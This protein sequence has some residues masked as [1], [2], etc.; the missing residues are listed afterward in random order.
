MANGDG[1]FN[2]TTLWIVGAVGTFM[3]FFFNK[4]N[5][6]IGRDEWNKKWKEH[7]EEHK[8]LKESIDKISIKI[9]E[10]NIHSIRTGETLRNLQTA[11]SNNVID[12]D[13][14]ASMGKVLKMIENGDFI[15]RD[16]KVQQ[17]GF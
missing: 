15:Q 3:T 8:D 17:D 5:G 14:L 7:K 4:L 9:E 1:I 16:K 12:R 2:Q 10:F 11:V 6:K 13:F